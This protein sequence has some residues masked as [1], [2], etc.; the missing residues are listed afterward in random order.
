MIYWRPLLSAIFSSFTDI[1]RVVI[2]VGAIAST[3]FEKSQID[4]LDLHPQCSNS[5]GKL[6]K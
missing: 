4:G 1:H 5:Y 3:L 2:T 6:G